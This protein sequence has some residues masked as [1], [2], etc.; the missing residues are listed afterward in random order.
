MK[1]LLLMLLGIG[2]VFAGCGEGDVGDSN[3][4]ITVE[5]PE[6]VNPVDLVLSAVE[7]TEAATSF[8]I[9]MELRLTGVP[10]VGDLIQP[11]SIEQAANGDNSLVVDLSDAT[12]GG[13]SSPSELVDYVFE[14][15]QVGDLLYIFLP[16]EEMVKFAETPWVSVARDQVSEEELDY[17]QGFDPN[18][19]LNFLLATDEGATIS[20]GEKVKDVA[21]TRVSGESTF[22]DVLN[23]LDVEERQ[24]MLD[25]FVSDFASQNASEEEIMSHLEKLHIEFDAWIGD[26]GYILREIIVMKNLYKFLVAV[27]SELRDEMDEFDDFVMSFETYFFDYGVPITIA[28]PP[29]EDVTPYEGSLDDLLP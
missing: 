5:D 14:M 22:K 7:Q 28:A 3:V 10:L 13:E 29:P 15:R 18:E 19:Q 24:E 11:A 20:L 25:S 21:A 16:K 9:D 27:D 23:S 17:F 2:L 4:V 26:D 12:I 8:R 6:A 1:R